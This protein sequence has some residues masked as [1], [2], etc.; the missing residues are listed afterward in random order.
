[1]KNKRNSDL[2]SV[3]EEISRDISDPSYE[4]EA[5]EE[6]IKENIGPIIN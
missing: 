3:E 1:M 4:E 2:Q 5:V 6:E